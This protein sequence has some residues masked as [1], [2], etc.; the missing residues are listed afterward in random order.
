MKRSKEIATTFISSLNAEIIIPLITIMVV[1]F[2][3]HFWHLKQ[4][5]FIADDWNFFA[6]IQADIIPT[7]RIDPF[8]YYRRPFEILIVELHNLLFPGLFWNFG[9]LHTYLVISTSA[10][11]FFL[12]IK[13]RFPLVFALIGAILFV[14]YPS[15]TT[16]PWLTLIIQQTSVTIAIIS[17]WLLYKKRYLLSALCL[18]SSDSV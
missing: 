7:F 5:G 8:Y 11:L 10:F 4:F 13:V 9:Y 3:A 6:K 1:T 12:I 15:D 2:V 18:L 17:V 14:L 16:R